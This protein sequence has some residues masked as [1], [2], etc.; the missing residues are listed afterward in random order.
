VQ[1]G[2]EKEQIVKQRIIQNQHA[3][4]VGEFYKSMAKLVAED[5][6]IHLYN[7]HFKGIPHDPEQIQRLQHSM[8]LLSEELAKGAEIQPSIESSVEVIKSFPDLKNLRS[9]KS[10]FK[11]IEDKK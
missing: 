6:A 7:E 2:K 11:R 5:E 1:E 9:I 3:I 8:Q 4:D 10:K